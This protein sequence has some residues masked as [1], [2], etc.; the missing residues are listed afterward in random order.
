MDAV[1][2]KKRLGRPP[3]RK[4]LLTLRLEPEVVAYYREHGQTAPFGWLQLVNDTL[5]QAMWD[6]IE[7]EKKRQERNAKRRAL[8]SKT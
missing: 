3:T 6:Q 1:V 2:E 7:Q 8:R 5:K 4:A